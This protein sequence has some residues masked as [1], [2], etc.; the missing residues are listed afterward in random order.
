MPDPIAERARL[1]AA[2]PQVPEEGQP[3]D[4]VE[5]APGHWVAAER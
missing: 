5:A 1:A 4:L 2:E 3:G